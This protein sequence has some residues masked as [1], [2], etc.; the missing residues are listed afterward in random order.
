LYES[1]FDSA[2]LFLARLNSLAPSLKP[3]YDTSF[4]NELLD[5]QKYQL[6]EINGEV[7]D[8]ALRAFKECAMPATYGA[9]VNSLINSKVTLANMQEIRYFTRSY[10]KFQSSPWHDV[11]NLHFREDVR[12]SQFFRP[13]TSIW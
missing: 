2:K 7:K 6:N 8:L 3:L 10:Q 1:D 5:E 11:R 13:L 9:F 12:K 4:L